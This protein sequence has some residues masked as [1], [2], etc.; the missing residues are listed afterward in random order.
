MLTWNTAAEWAAGGGVDLMGEFYGNDRSERWLGVGM[1]W[2]VGAW[3]VNGAA[4][5]QTSAPKASLLTV[6]AKLNF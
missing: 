2:T 5:R 4:A 6:G 1:R 3:S